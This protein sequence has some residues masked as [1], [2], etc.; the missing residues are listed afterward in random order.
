M[1][2]AEKR[3]TI[4]ELPL[5]CTIHLKRF[6]YLQQGYIHKIGSKVQ[7]PETLDLAPYVSEDQ[8]VQKAEYNLYAVLVHSGRRCDSGHYYAYIKA[9]NQHWYKADD[10]SVTPVKL[11]EV[12]NQQAY[13]LFYQKVQP[14][15]TSELP[16]ITSFKAPRKE[17]IPAKKVLVKRQRPIEFDGQVATETTTANATPNITT[18]T[19][20][21]AKS[22]VTSTTTAETS[23]VPTH[24]T[25]KRKLQF[26]EPTVIADN[27]KAWVVQFTMQPHRSLRGNLSPPTYSANVSD[28]SSWLVQS[29]SDFQHHQ[30]SNNRLCRSK[31]KSKKSTWT[32][33]SL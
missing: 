28:L 17:I 22:T 4:D 10:E 32:E 27:P 1:V 11:E 29:T 15:S 26:I 23:T 20:S 24:P 7:F 21:A 5:M 12:L 33:T 13:M 9:P 31:L 18:T 8:R 2:T 16:P 30:K 6:A 25:K 19:E 14:E 3:M